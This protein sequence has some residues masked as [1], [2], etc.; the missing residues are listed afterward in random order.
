[1]PPA[2]RIHSAWYLLSDYI[3]AVLSWCVLYFARRYLL[4]EIII[5]HDGVVLNDRFWYGITLIPIAWILFYSMVGSYHSL[6]R[7][8]RLN[9]LAITF[10][11]CLIG[12]TIIFFSI[13]INDPQTQYTYY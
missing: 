4:H 11:C 2:K 6:Y 9:E 5:H 1:M 3:A 10:L 8:S 12:S 13:V 7:K